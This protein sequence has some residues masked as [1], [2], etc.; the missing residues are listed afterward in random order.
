MRH[1]SRTRSGTAVTRTQASA[2]QTLPKIEDDLR[3]A[4]EVAKTT[5]IGTTTPSRRKQQHHRGASAS[6]KHIGARRNKSAQFVPSRFGASSPHVCRHMME[7]T[8]KRFLIASLA[9]LLT[10]A[11]IGLSYAGPRSGLYGDGNARSDVYVIA[12]RCAP[13]PDGCPQ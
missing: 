13:P 3:R 5:E 6:R 1:P 4:L 7:A 11:S 10:T 8:M 9:V 2:H 12:G